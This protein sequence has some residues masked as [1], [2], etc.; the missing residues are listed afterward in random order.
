VKKWGK[1]LPARASIDV[2]GK[3]SG[4]VESKTEK[5]IQTLTKGPTEGQGAAKVRDD[6]WPSSRSLA[7]ASTAQNRRKESA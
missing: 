2:S 6:L 1:T 7:S 4:R 5:E 3:E